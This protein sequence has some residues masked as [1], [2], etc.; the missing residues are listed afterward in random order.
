MNI[1]VFSFPKEGVKPQI[2]DKW[3]GAA[4]HL[5]LVPHALALPNSFLKTFF[6]DSRSRS[7]IVGDLSEH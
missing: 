1:Y 7:G 5:V 4:D 6:R 3:D 2:R